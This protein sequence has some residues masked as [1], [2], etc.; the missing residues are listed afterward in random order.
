VSSCTTTT[1]TQGHPR[2]MPGHGPLYSPEH[3]P[4]L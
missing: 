2:G 1:T 3:Q 4:D